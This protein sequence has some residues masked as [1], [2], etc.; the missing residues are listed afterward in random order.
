MKQASF[1]NNDA[2]LRASY[3][4]TPSVQW[5]RSTVEQLTLKGYAATLTHAKTPPCPVWPEAQIR[6][7]ARGHAGD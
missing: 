2:P 7:S 4:E 3:E 5:A 6:G 1:N